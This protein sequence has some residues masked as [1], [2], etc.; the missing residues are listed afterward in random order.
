MDWLMHEKFSVSS[1]VSEKTSEPF[2]GSCVST[3]T[4]S[5]VIEMELI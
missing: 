2:S 1:S 5:A 4:Y 3:I